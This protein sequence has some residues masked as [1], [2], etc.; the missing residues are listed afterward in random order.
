[1]P[2]QQLDGRQRAR[3]DVLR[4]D[5]G[6]RQ[7]AVLKELTPEK[8]NL[9]LK[10]SSLAVLHPRGLFGDGFVLTFILPEEAF[11]HILLPGKDLLL[12]TYHSSDTPPP[13]P[14]FPRSVAVTSTSAR[15]PRSR[16]R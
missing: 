2:P 9:L 5:I 15:K 1:P 7:T 6:E 10:P 4:E 3:D 13:A 14:Q 16:A 11:R 8:P 12:S